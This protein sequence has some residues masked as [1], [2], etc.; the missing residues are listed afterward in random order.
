VREDSFCIFFYIFLK[1]SKISVMEG[2]AELVANQL[3]QKLLI[4]LMRKKSKLRFYKGSEACL[5]MMYYS[6]L[7]IQFYLLNV[8]FILVDG[9][10]SLTPF[11]A[12]CMI[13]PNSISFY[14]FLCRA[15]N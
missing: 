5:P 3:T 6:L 13:F 7:A 1:A 2:G 9:L 14:L 10:H 4:K 8:N 11:V 15:D 12:P